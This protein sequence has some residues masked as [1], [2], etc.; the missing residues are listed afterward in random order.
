M[1]KRNILFISS[2][3]NAFSKSRTALSYLFETAVYTPALAELS[4]DISCQM[5][6][7]RYDLSTQKKTDEAVNAFRNAEGLVIASPV[8][9]WS[10]SDKLFHFLNLAIDSEDN[11]NFVPVM[12]ILGAGSTSSV[13]ADESLNRA[14]MLEFN[15]IIVG[16]PC[17]MVKESFESNDKHSLNEVAKTRLALS[18]SELIKI[19][20]R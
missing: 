1:T 12:R 6:D 2:S 14:L 11:K 7:L 13:F 4:H 3:D 8:F 10:V 15:A 18:F 5:I 16:K 17:V 19:V 20:L 9:N